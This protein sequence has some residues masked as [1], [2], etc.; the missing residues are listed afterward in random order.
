MFKLLL[1]LVLVLVLVV[2]VVVVVVV[3][4]VVVVV[5]IQIRIHLNILSRL[6]LGIPR[7]ITTTKELGRRKFRRPI[8][9]D[10]FVLHNLVLAALGVFFD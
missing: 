9:F 4:V 1:V 2:V 8:A 7:G 10:H 6:S 5:E 3:I